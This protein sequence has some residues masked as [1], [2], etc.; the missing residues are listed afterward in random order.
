[1]NGEWWIMNNEL[2]EYYW[3]YK[4]NYN[5]KWVRWFE[6]TEKD[7]ENKLWKEKRKRQIKNNF[8]TRG[9]WFPF[10]KEK[11]GIDIYD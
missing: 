1:M 4:F 2:W 10:I 7:V 3:N 5:T 6:Y 11:T 9:I 8:K